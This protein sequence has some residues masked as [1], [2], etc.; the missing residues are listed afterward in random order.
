[1]KTIGLIGGMS[2]ESTAHYYSLL[3]K[4]VKQRLGGHHSAKLLLYSI[5]FDELATLQ[6]AQKWD[7]ATA[8]MVDAARRL[9]RGG[10][11]FVLIGSNTMHISAEAVERSV[12][13]PLLHVADA[14]GER[15]VAR[16]IRRAGLLGTAFTMEQ[17]FYRDRLH[18]KFGLEV[19]VP[20][21][22]RRREVH[23]IIYCELVHGIVSSKAKAR[24]R[25]I[26]A[27]LITQG[28]GAIILGCTELMMIVEPADS[29]VPL[30]D[31][32]TIHSEAAVE[33]ALA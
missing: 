12:A 24:L 13:I 28:A 10:A 14:T 9:E 30:F 19:S 25:Q 33:H 18:E 1:M 29:A 32:T 16:G 3:N 23:D 11:D 31:T 5:D 26:I 2:W 20:E 7:E 21:P 27:E 22:E 17:S 15:L 6:F 8:M 4:L